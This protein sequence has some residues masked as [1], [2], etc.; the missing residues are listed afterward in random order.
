MSVYI[1]LS[2]YSRRRTVCIQ[3]V[4]S[5]FSVCLRRVWWCKEDRFGKAS[6]SGSTQVLASETRVQ[7]LTVGDVIPRDDVSGDHRVGLFRV[8]REDSR[9]R[10]RNLGLLPRT[11]MSLP[12]CRRDDRGTPVVWGERGVEARVGPP[13]RGPLF[14]APRPTLSWTSWT[15]TS[16][17]VGVGPP[18]GPDG[19]YWSE[20]LLVTVSPTRPS[21]FPDFR[22]P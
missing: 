17:L 5:L 12:K 14:P 1:E 16:C 6:L 20:T 19:P 21:G 9:R 18:V 7:T 11:P 22:P 8:F 3:G 4:S 15:S 13:P 2:V 10:D